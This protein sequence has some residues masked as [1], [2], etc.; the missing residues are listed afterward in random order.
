MSSSFFSYV[1]KV[2]IVVSLSL[3]KYNKQEVT[4]KLVKE[5]ME[6]ISLPFSPYMTN[7]YVLQT[8]EN[9]CVAQPIGKDSGG[10]EKQ[11]ET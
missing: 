5:Q 1:S 3:L 10:Q 6:L 9:F 4:L 8:T 7:N 2:F 11:C